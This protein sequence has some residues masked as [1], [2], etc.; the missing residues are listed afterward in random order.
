M[1]RTTEYQDLD[2]INNPSIG[3]GISSNSGGMGSNLMYLL[4]G[5]GIGATLALLFAPK[6]GSE[7]RQD[8][9]SAAQ[10]GYDETLEL[11]GKLKD[12]SAHLYEVVKDKT[13]QVYNFAAEKFKLEGAR[14]PGEIADRVIEGG[15]QLADQGLEAASDTVNKEKFGSQPLDIH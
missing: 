2:R 5:G 14:T 3:G 10:R 1:N 6:P 7:L 11:A 8:I 4:I 15:R 9:G 12:Q 13:D